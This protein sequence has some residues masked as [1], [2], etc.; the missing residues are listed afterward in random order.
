MRGYDKERDIEKLE[1]TL[2]AIAGMERLLAS[3]LRDEF[4]EKALERYFEIIGEACR[5]ISKNIRDKYPYIPW[6]NIIAL[7]N[8]ISHEYDKIEITTLWEIAEHKIPALKDW[9]Q[10]IL[11][12]QK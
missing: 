12:E 5:G 6:S 8:I 1:D 4:A 7:R 10:G 9:I 11:D 2:K 3:E